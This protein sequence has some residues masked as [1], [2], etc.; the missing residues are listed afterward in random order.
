MSMKGNALLTGTY[1]FLGAHPTIHFVANGDNSTG[2][3]RRLDC[4]PALETLLLPSF[5]QLLNWVNPAIQPRLV[6]RGHPRIDHHANATQ[7]RYGQFLNY[8][9]AVPNCAGRL[10]GLGHRSAA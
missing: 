8:Q 4:A 9:Q 3:L 6:H 1:G 5:T 2:T 10:L 7:S